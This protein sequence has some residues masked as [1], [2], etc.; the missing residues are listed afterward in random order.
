MHPPTHSRNPAGTAGA[1]ATHRQRKKPRT[2]ETR[3]T[4]ASHTEGRQFTRLTHT[5]GSSLTH[6]STHAA[7]SRA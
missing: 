4:D 1:H 7:T 5:E 3:T 6:T 2:A